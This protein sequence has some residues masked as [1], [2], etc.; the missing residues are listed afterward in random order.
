[1]FV[2]HYIVILYN[3]IHCIRSNASKNVVDYY[4]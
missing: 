3:V 1:M 2:I 4:T